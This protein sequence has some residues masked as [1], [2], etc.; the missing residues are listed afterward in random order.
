MSLKEYFDQ[1]AS[2]W[3]SI[4]GPAVAVKLE[5]ILNSCCIPNGAEILDAA[6]GTGII[7]PILLEAVGSSGTVTAVDFAPEMIIRARAKNFGPNARFLV[8]DVMDLPFENCTFD[9][10][11]CNGSLP[12]FPDLK[13]SLR[14]MKRVLKNGGRLIISHANSREEINATHRKIGG[15]V[16]DDLLPT[17]VEL[18]SML[19]NTGYI[20][21]NFED[22]PDRFVFLATKPSA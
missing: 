21:I 8:A 10:V 22:K 4:M 3:D 1:V 6:C 13:G 18:E 11:V 2:K 12:H 7:T 15:P 19:K 5:E 20:E 17:A 16:A 14:E 9:L